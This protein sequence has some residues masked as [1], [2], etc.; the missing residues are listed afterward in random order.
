MPSLPELRILPGIDEALPV[1]LFQMR[2]LSEVPVIAPLLASQERVQGMMK[3]VI[4]LGIQAIAACLT[5]VDDPDVVQI[6]LR[7][8]IDF[9]AQHFRFS[10]H[11]FP[12]F[13]QEVSRAEIEYPVDGIDPDGIDMILRDPVEGIVYEKS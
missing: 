13:L 9:S 1:C 11:R 5:G 3:V 12:E 7:D 6:A 8:H 4:P 2:Y 10:V